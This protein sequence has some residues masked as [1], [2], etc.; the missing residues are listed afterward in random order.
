MSVTKYKSSVSMILDM[1]KENELLHRKIVDMIESI[2]K[3]IN[4]KIEILDYKIQESAIK[5]SKL[6]DI[7]TKESEEYEQFKSLVN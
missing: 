1:I 5:R 3:K 4:T 2:G 6:K 7:L